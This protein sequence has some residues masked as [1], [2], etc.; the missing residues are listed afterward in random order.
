[1]QVMF[2]LLAAI[3]PVP[4]DQV[5]VPV[6]EGIRFW[7][8]LRGNQS[9]GLIKKDTPKSQVVSQLG[10]PRKGWRPCFSFDTKQKA[11]RG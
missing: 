10:E 3:V 4:G 5:G 7:W 6:F 11:T 2:L 1:M 9:E 8:V